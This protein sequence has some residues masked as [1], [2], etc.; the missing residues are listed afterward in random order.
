MGLALSLLVLGSA[1]VIAGAITWI[2]LA[3]RAKSRDESMD[4]R[5]FWLIGPLL[6]LGV[7]MLIGS[8]ISYAQR[9]RIVVSPPVPPDWVVGVTAPVARSI[10]PIGSTR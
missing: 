3:Q 4:A 9:P 2:V 7:L 10:R 8:G 6:G 5:W 1:F